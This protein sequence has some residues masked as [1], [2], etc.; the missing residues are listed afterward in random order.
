MD[1]AAL[2]EGLKNPT[3]LYKE[4]RTCGCKKWGKYWRI[5]EREAIELARQGMSY[6][7]P[8]FDYCPFCGDALKRR[9]IG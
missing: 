5:A 4:I 9:S 8:A 7:G 2:Q 6:N 3:I 1:S